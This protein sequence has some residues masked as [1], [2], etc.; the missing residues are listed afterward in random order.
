[1]DRKLLDAL[2]LELR[3]SPTV[4][5]TPQ[6]FCHLSYVNCLGSLGLVG[7]KAEDAQLNHQ[8]SMEVQEQQAHHTELP[9]EQKE[10]L[11]LTTV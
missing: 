7:A 6:S 11:P 2:L 3:G 4:Y 5:S 1:M 9:I 10:A 8:E